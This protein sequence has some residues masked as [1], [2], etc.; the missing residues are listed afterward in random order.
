MHVSGKDVARI[1]HLRIEEMPKPK[2]GAGEILVKVRAAAICGTDVR[3]LAGGAKG[4]DSSQPLVLGHE[5]AGDIVEIGSAVTGY[6]S[7]H[8]SQQWRLIWAAV[9]V[10]YAS[11]A[12]DIY[13]Q[14]Y[15][16]F[17]HQSGRRFRGIR[18]NSLPRR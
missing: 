4:T 7:R 13:V 6:Q 15:Q 14:H 17:R 10:I 8:A 11:A 3:M 16:A 1:D 12:T 2:I 18:Q 9:C 5:F